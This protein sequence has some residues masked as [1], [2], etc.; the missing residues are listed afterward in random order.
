MRLS[1]I[2]EGHWVAAPG[3]Y[4]GSLYNGK[5]KAKRH[6]FLLNPDDRERFASNM[7]LSEDVNDIKYSKIGDD[8]EF[9]DKPTPFFGEE[10][11]EIKL[12]PPPNNSSDTT[13]SEL[14]QLA[15]R[16]SNLSKKERQSIKD[17]DIDNLEN[18]FIELLESDGEIVSSELKSK[19]K[20]ISEELTTIGIFF[21]L[22]FDRARPYQLMDEFNIRNDIK[23]GKTTDSP[24]YPSTHAIIGRYLAKWLSD[25]FPDQEKELLK[26]GY[27]LGYNR[28][29]AGFHYPSDFDAGVMLANKLL[30]M[31]K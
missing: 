9:T 28:V 15:Y 21:K 16:S 29:L 23:R 12:K 22:K 31:K 5:K 1:Q 26:L 7:G 11:Q 4:P 24:S 2:I 18:V 3:K 25:K 10:W 17:Q 14:E 27:D 8:I 6:S 19:V 30:A 13:K 20:Q